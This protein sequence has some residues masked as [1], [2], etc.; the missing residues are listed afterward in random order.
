LE[1]YFLGKGIYFADMISVSASYCKATKERP[2]GLVL[3][4]D[5]ALGRYFGLN[6]LLR[7]IFCDLC[8]H[9]M[10]MHD[11]QSL[12]NIPWKVLVQ[13]GF[14]YCWISF[15]EVLWNKRTR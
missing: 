14:E 4:C 12:S 2:Y 6:F 13:R 3:L 9:L 11:A 10:L 5:V 8:L 7:F 1:G 15:S